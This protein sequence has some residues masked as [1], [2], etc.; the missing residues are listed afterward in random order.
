MGA[1]CAP[2]DAVLASRNLKNA[3][4]GRLYARLCGGEIWGEW[5]GFVKEAEMACFAFASM[6]YI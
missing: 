4:Q 3:R 6:T 5:F 1:V 2:D